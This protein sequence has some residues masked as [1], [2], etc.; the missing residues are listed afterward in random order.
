MEYYKISPSQIRAYVAR[1]FQ[2]KTRKNGKELVIV[3]PFRNDG[4]Y[5]FNI[6]P[7]LG[8]CHD[9]RSDAW[10]GPINPV[11]G[12][13]YCTFLKFVQLHQNCSFAQAI[14][15][16]GG[17]QNSVD[18]II[19]DDKP[20]N[21]DYRPIE[22]PSGVVDF[23]FAN[24][25]LAD[26]IVINWLN[27]RGVT[28]EMIVK[29]KMKRLVT[30]VVW[31]YFEFDKM[32]YWQSRSAVQKVFEFPSQSIYGVSKGE[33]LYGFDDVEPASYVVVAE[34]IFVALSIGD[35]CVSSGGA[36]L[37]DK[38][39]RK[40]KLLGPRDGIVLAADR[41]KAGFESIISNG[42]KLSDIGIS[43]HYV[44]PPKIEYTDVDGRVR[45]VKDWN[46]LIEHCH[47]THNAVRSSFESSICK[48]DFQARF[49]LAGMI[50][51][52][53]KK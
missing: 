31:P 49:K 34:S 15:I 21:T 27:R 36:S 25:S 42:K 46:E 35:Q 13:R 39:I 53:S 51:E 16:L 44:L 33:Y 28:N 29:H 11:T 48:L 19:V 3:N 4:E 5:K 24:C 6:N 18:P 10:A 32:V 17:I 43:V 9:W 37:T 22:L 8:Y 40:I 52:S 45:V 47:W 2:F 1:H 7:E 20:D 50:N 26:A 14:E 38:Q 12:K 30:S 41:D 23:D